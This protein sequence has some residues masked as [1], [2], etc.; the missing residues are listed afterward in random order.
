[1]GPT[2][3]D[4]RFSDA[5]PAT[6]NNEPAFEDLETDSRTAILGTYA[7]ASSSTQRE[8]ELKTALSGLFPVCV[9]VDA[10][11]NGPIQNYVVGGSVVENMGTN[12]DHY[13]CCLAYRSG[14]NGLE[15]GIMNSWGPLYGENGLFWIGKQSI[16]QLG[17]IIVFDVRE[18]LDP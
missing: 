1:M 8:Q 11:D 10:S 18:V 4:G 13:V 16:Q 6:I 15:L 17:D 3:Q 12:L 2:P 5:D 7:I 9:A 14:E